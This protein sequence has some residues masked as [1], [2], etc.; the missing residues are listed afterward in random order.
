MFVSFKRAVLRTNENSARIF[1]PYIPFSPTHL[2]VMKRK[3][4]GKIGEKKKMKMM[5]LSW[6]YGIL[7]WIPYWSELAP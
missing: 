5:K 1:I 2:L 4:Y 7:V 3:K 6:K